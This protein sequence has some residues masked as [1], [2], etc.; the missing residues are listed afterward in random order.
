M[1]QFDIEGLARVN[2]LATQCSATIRGLPEH[3]HVIEQLPFEPDGVGGHVWLKIQKRGINTDWLAG[4]LAKFAGVPQVA[5][6]YAGLKDRHAVTTQWFS[7]NMEGVEQ[8]NWSEFASDDITIVEQTAHGKKLKRGVLAGNQFKLILSDVLGERE[9]WQQ[10]LELVKQQGVPNYFGEQRFGHNGSNLNRADYWFVSGK[11]PKKRNQKSI[12]LS[13]ARSWLFNLILARRI[14]DRNWNKALM[15]DVMALA[16]TKA[17]SFVC[18][19]V[20]EVVKAR[21]TAMDIHPTGALW[22]RGISPNHSDSLQC[23][24]DVLNQ[25]QDWQHGLEK[26]GLSQERRSLRLF[27]DHFSWQ[28]LDDAQ[29]ELQ[30]FLPAGC[31]AT[32]IMRELAIISD[33]Q[34]RNYYQDS[35]AIPRNEADTK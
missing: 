29:L 24:Q 8:P 19:Q 18:D 6:G 26:A 21:V 1:K 27:P 4:E 35:N 32:A 16:G 13:A 12:Y 2:T 9:Q 10:A 23:E 33:A 22:G 11:A 28:F 3:F 34:H 14:Q 31:Y 17:S 20:D 25:W 15:G 7:V 5:I 30:F